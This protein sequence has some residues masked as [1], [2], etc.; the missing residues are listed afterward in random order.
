MT[1]YLKP[2]YDSRQSFY[3][4]AVVETTEKDFNYDGIALTTEKELYLVYN[5]NNV[6]L[7]K[8]LGNAYSIYDT[9]IVEIVDEYFDLS[10]G[11]NII[12]IKIEIDSNTFFT[13][14]FYSENI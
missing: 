8:N 1:E 3:K 5:E 11:Y 2:I 10:F 6:I 4:K 9:F 7:T 12:T 14:N 13:C